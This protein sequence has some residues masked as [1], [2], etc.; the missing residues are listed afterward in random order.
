[1][2]MEHRYVSRRTTKQWNAM[3]IAVLI[4]SLLIVGCS[5][6]APAVQPEL[7]ALAEQNPDSYVR[8]IIQKRSASDAAEKLVADLGGVVVRD[9]NLI[10]SFSAEVPASAVVQLAES[11]RGQVDLSGCAY[12]IHTGG[13]NRQPPCL[14]SLVKSAGRKG[15]HRV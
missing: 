15:T 13:G 9:L 6:P 14:H 5:A 10:N 8:V 7:L 11:R 2:N 3:M 1:M 12:A 4:I